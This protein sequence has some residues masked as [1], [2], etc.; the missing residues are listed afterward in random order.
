MRTACAQA[1]ARL[2]IAHLLSRGASP[3]AAVGKSKKQGESRKNKNKTLHSFDHRVIP[4]SPSS[5]GPPARQYQKRMRLCPSAHPV[6]KIQ[7]TRP[8]ALR[9]SCAMPGAPSQPAFVCEKQW[10]WHTWGGGVAA[11][12]TAA[13]GGTEGATAI[14]A[15]CAELVGLLIM[16]SIACCRPTC[17][18]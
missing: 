4:P 6:Q 17:T 2:R 5:C 1:Y 13:A 11:E 8:A 10:R 12:G 18:R 3:E 9:K 15:G 7:F 14:A 16:K